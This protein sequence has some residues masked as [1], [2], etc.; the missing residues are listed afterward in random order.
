MNCITSLLILNLEDPLILIN[1]IF[2][3]NFKLD[4]QIILQSKDQEIQEELTSI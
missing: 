2:I 4:F 1:S 3:Q